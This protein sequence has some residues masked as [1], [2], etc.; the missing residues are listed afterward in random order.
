MSE[1]H[2]S[3]LD[4]V[5]TWAAGLVGPSFPIEEV[6]LS[7][8]WFDDRLPCLAPPS[9][10][11]VPMDIDRNQLVLWQVLSTYFVDD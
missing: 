2:N 9:P 4:D 5:E 8:S 3:I 7:G 1:Q 11:N 6:L 10:S